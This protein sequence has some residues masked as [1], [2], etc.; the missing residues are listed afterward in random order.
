MKNK[1]EESIPQKISKT[2]IQL[3]YDKNVSEKIY[4]N[5]EMDNEYSITK[6]FWKKYA[7]T[8]KWIVNTV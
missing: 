6:M 2:A 3:K 4:D 8:R 1:N 5:K 7:I